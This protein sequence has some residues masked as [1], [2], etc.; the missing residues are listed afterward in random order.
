[1]LIYQLHKL[2]NNVNCKVEITILQSKHLADHIPGLSLSQRLYKLPLTTGRRPLPLSSYNRPAVPAPPP[3]AEELK[4][5]PTVVAPAA[6]ADSPVK[7]P[8]LEVKTEP[9]D[10]F[11]ASNVSFVRHLY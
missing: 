1:M 5:G 2:I 8:K 7:K 4:R 3:R 10:V 9:A 6:A 11:S